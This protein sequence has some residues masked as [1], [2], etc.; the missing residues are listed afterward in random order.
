MS[1]PEYAPE[2]DRDGTPLA[3]GDRV[4]F[5]LYPRGTARGTVVVSDRVRVVVDGAALPALAIKADDGTVYT[6]HSGGVR[7]LK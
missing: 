7:K 2:E 6:L 3:P 4:S 1:A 5:K